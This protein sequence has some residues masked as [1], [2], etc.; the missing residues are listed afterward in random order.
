MCR[1]GD[2]EKEDMPAWTWKVIE[3]IWLQGLEDVIASYVYTNS[4]CVGTARIS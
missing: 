3:I 1:D 4:F 2:L